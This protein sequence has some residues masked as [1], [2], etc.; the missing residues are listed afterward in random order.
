MVRQDCCIRTS[1]IRPSLSPLHAGP[2]GMAGPP[3]GLNRQVYYEHS[4]GVD[5]ILRPTVAV[6]DGRR[7]RK[8]TEVTFGRREGGGG[9][10]GGGGERLRERRDGEEGRGK[11]PLFVGELMLCGMQGSLCHALII[12]WGPHLSLI[13]YFCCSTVFSTI[14]A[15]N[16]SSLKVSLID[17][18]WI[19]AV[20]PVPRPHPL[21]AHVLF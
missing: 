9:G 2:G 6:I 7:Y 10:G 19:F 3:P 1:S 5:E 11:V 20:A 13:V 21:L 18:F 15:G 17:C 14:I 8:V 12:K 16:F 4:S